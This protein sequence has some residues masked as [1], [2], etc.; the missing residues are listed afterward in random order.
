MG[1]RDRGRVYHPKG[2]PERAPIPVKESGVEAKAPVVAKEVAVKPPPGLV[3]SMPKMAKA[4][5]TKGKG[6]GKGK[7][8]GK[9]GLGQGSNE[10]TNG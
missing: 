6:E 1:I 7:D 2:P 9:D 3:I 4:T 10:R 5:T 8:E